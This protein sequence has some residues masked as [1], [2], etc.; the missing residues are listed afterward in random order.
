MSVTKKDT[1]YAANLARLGLTED[2]KELFTEQL[3]N[4]LGYID[5]INSVDTKNVR[6]AVFYG[7]GGSAAFKTP[8]R[9]DKSYPFKAP[10]KIMSIAPKQEDNMF[11]VP[12]ILE[13]EE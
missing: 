4:I 1:E 7:P 13:T 10:G 2:E 12:R 3:N 9:E 6:P 8:M 5:A 11:R